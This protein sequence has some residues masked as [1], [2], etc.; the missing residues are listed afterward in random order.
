MFSSHATAELFTPPT[1]RS[2]P[3]ASWSPFALLIAWQRRIAARDA[4]SEMDARM[5]ADIGLTQ[6]AIAI[7]AEK[8]FWRA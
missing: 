2:R 4:L 1:R 8:P 3:E 6:D 5:R 7:E